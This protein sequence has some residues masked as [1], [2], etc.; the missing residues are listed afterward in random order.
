MNR[1]I[2]I[3]LLALAGC[4][5]QPAPQVVKVPTP[6]YCEPDDV[7]APALPIDQLQE[8]AD[9][10]DVTRALWATVEMQEGYQVKLRAAVDA[11]RAKKPGN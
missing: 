1:M 3:L 7:P 11:C 6:V 10:Y 5:G 9:D 4:A 2:G 8:G